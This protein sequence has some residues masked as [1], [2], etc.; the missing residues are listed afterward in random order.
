MCLISMVC[1]G[2]VVGRTG[3]VDA[4]WSVRRRAVEWMFLRGVNILDVDGAAANLQRRHVKGLLTA[5]IA[6]TVENLPTSAAQKNPPQWWRQLRGLIYAP[7]ES[8][9]QVSREVVC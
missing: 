8:Y 5:F 6:S 3:D 7:V 2:A 1:L 4:E 9:S